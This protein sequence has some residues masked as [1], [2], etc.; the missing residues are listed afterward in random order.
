MKNLVPLCGRHHHLVHDAGFTATLT[1]GRTLRWYRPDG[2]HDADQP[3]RP[4]TPRPATT[5]SGSPPDDPDD[6]GGG[7]PDDGRPAAAPPGHTRDGAGEQLTLV[8]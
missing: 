4:R 6:P 8:A 5:S 7:E 3:L 1:A 2:T